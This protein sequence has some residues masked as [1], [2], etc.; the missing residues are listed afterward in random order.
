MSNPSDDHKPLLRQ[1]ESIIDLSREDRAALAT[2]PLRTRKVAEKRDI[3]REGSR[4]A[5]CCIVLEGIVCRYKMLSNGRRQILS[6]HFAGDMPD[7][8]S[9]DLDV[10]D[11]SLASITA[12]RVAFVPHEAVRALMKK[13]AGVSAALSR[14]AQIDGSIFREWISNIGRRTALERVGHMI[15][16][17]FVRMRALGVTTLEDF[18]LPMTQT[19]IADATGLSNVHV[20]RTMKELRRLGLV[21][22]NGGVNAILDWELLQETAGFDP[23]YL[24]LRRQSPP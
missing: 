13:N 16:E 17:C 20:N 10:M 15:C 4:T 19:E 7:L 24:H 12:A 14:H 2:L 1:L 8:Q 11:H 18:E 21:A 3:L 9:L 6:F 23:A 22:S 5:E